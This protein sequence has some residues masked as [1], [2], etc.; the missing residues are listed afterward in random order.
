MCV[1]NFMNVVLPLLATA[2]HVLTVPSE[3]DASVVLLLQ[4]RRTGRVQSQHALQPQTRATSLE[5]SSG[6]NDQFPSFS[7]R[8]AI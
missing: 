2:Q 3:P 6:K 7:L 5:E 1:Y 4:T 8:G